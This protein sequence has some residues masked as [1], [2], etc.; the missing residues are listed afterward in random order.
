ME[1]QVSKFLDDLAKA[2]AQ[3]PP[4][5]QKRILEDGRRLLEERRRRAEEGE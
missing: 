2:L 1:D 5:G 3:L 4:E